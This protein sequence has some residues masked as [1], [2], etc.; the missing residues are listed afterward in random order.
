M[1]DENQTIH[2]CGLDFE[3]IGH[4]ITA[5]QDDYLMGHLRLAGVID[6][7]ATMREADAEE[8]SAELL[9]RILCSGHAPEILA[10]LLTE[11]GRKWNRK[12]ADEFA[13]MFADAT[14]PIDKATMRSSMISF[15][16]GFFLSGD[17]SSTSSPKSSIPNS[18]EP[19][20]ESA[21]L[22]TSATSL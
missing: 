1:N 2:L 5:R 9:T 21:E 18:E 14:D 11:S 3:L 16:L 8:K 17:R 15:V 19:T 4:S 6:V 13:T 20:T 7:V 10:G 22:A 12:R